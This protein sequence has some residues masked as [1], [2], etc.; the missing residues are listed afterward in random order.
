M[1]EFL[2]SYLVFN[3]KWFISRDGYRPRGVEGGTVG[4]GTDVEFST[5]I[6][7]IFTTFTFY[8]V[9]RDDGVYPR[10]LLSV[11]CN[12]DF[13]FVLNLYVSLVQYL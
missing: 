2:G 12:H 1:L 7:F 9:G 8:L 11:Y 3:E 13:S 10:G 5:D 4:G 6:E